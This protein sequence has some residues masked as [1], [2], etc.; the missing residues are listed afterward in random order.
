MKNSEQL[1]LETLN[2]TELQ[3]V[4]GGYRHICVL[5]IKLIL[6]ILNGNID[7]GEK[8]STK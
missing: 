5:P 1:G 4:E 2:S 6:A 3:Q 7:P 8:E